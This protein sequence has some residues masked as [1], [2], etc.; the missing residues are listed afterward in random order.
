VKN[1][2]LKTVTQ[3]IFD[4]F[5]GRRREVAVHEVGHFALAVAGGGLPRAI[6][7]GDNTFVGEDALGACGKCSNAPPGVYGI[8]RRAFG[9]N[10]RLAVQLAIGENIAGYVAEAR[11]TRTTLEA[12]LEQTDDNDGDLLHAAAWA[13]WYRG[14]PIRDD[15]WRASSINAI[16]LVHRIARKADSYLVLHWPTVMRMARALDTRGELSEGSISAWSS[17]FPIVSP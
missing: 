8:S 5:P 13:S 1:E 2:T 6:A 3:T 11:H 15:D 7:I 9:H 12:L 14:E 17:R 10:A 4:A 16:K